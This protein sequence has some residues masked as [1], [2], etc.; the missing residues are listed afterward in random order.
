MAFPRARGNGVGEV[1]QFRPRTAPEGAPRVS[2]DKAVGLVL[3]RLAENGLMGEADVRA[4]LETLRRKS[5]WQDAPRRRA[6]GA[7]V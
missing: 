3:A 2:F 7:T 6:S 5:G 4:A 1:L